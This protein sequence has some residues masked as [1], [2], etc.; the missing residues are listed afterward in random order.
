[1]CSSFDLMDGNVPGFP[2]LYYLLEFA[3]IYVHLVS[4]AIKPSHP[5]LPSSHSAFNLSHHQ[6]LF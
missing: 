6:S 4:G 3:Q 1:M 5:L 2:V